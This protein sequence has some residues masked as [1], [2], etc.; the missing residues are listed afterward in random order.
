MACLGYTADSFQEASSEG[1]NKG[2]LRGQLTVGSGGPKQARRAKHFP[3]QVKRARRA[4]RSPGRPVIKEIPA[5]AI[6]YSRKPRV[7][8]G[9][10]AH[11]RS[12]EFR[13]SIFFPRPTAMAAGEIFFLRAADG[14]MSE[15]AT[16]VGGGSV[17]DDEIVVFPGGSGR[18]VL[19]HGGSV[20]DDEHEP[21]NGKAM[22]LPVQIRQRADDDG[23][24]RRDE[25]IR[26]SSGEQ[27]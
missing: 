13:C 17:I 10:T 5:Y 6:T 20:I 26:N 2:E 21:I 15:P 1:R 14:A 25:R 27:Q 3:S 4:R 22:S 12:I 16:P 24:E 23:S 8:L 19:L 9:I 7:D 11:R 18:I